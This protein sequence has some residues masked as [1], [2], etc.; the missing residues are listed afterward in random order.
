MRNKATIYICGLLVSLLLASSCQLDEFDMNDL[1][2]EKEI[3][4]GW[5]APLIKGELSTQDL[6]ETF[7]STNAINSEADGLLYLVYK[8]SLYSRTA[9][10]EVE[11][12]NQDY[13]DLLYKVPYTINNFTG[14]RTETKDTTHKIVF[15]SDEQLDSIITDR[16]T[17]KQHVTSDIEHDIEITITY[18]DIIKNGEP[19]V[20][21]INIPASEIPY[22]EEL[23]EDLTGY[24]IQTHSF[25]TSEHKYF[26]MH[27]EVTIN[28]TGNDLNEGEE[29][30]IQ[31]MIEDVDMQSAYGYIG[32]DTLM[33]K[34][35]DI[36]LNL[37]FDAQEGKIEF[38]APELKFL[39]ENS[40][41]LP[42]QIELKDAKAYT[43]G[44]SD[45]T[46]I[47]FEDSANIFDINYPR[48]SQNEI[49]ETKKDT[50]KISNNIC[51]LSEALSTNPTHIKFTSRGKSNPNGPEA[52]NFVTDNSQFKVF[53]EL[54][55]PLHLRAKGFSLKD[56]MELDMSDILGE[57]T[58]EIK[59]VITKFK[60][61]NGLPADVDFQVY[62]LDST[63][64]MVDTLFNP[65]DR[66]VIESA[67]TDIEGVVASSTEKTAEMV[68]NENDINRLK[69]VRHAIF[70]AGLSTEDFETENKVKFYSHYTFKF[71]MNVETEINL[72]LNN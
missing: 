69:D 54:Y 70:E 44:N 68:F 8:D 30:S 66:P 15:E 7:D 22:D 34:E 39:I 56:T 25:D 52:Y 42:I 55:L 37:F 9:K 32:Q 33:L 23:T 62:F 67:T 5:A 53:S 20:D 19:L 10:D 58:E 17:L 13:F 38:A 14:S 65:G 72:N 51:N 48:F 45:S 63:Y 59:E 2:E 6:L 43:Q 46:D 61:I 28:G 12:P 47:M 27:Y 64:Q 57:D 11:L 1:S 4:Q 29:V 40:Y 50:V 36:P 18:T 49:G 16:F 21:N 3:G 24:T 60:T 35:G 26:R 41:G 31:T 71:R